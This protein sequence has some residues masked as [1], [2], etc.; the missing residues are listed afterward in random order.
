MEKSDSEN[1]IAVFLGMLGV[2]FIFS[3]YSNYQTMKFF[4][5]VNVII[6]FVIGVILLLWVYRLVRK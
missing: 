6:P 5:V 1:I 4:D 3:G 2:F